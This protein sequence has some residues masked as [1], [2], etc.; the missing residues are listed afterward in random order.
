M[1]SR[2]LALVNPGT[3]DRRPLHQAA[4][5]AKAV[6]GELIVHAVLFDPRLDWDLFSPGKDGHAEAEQSKVEEAARADLERRCEGLAIAPTAIDVSWGHPLDEALKPVLEEHAIDLLVFS[7]RNP[8]GDRLSRAEWHLLRR[9]KANVWLARSGRFPDRPVIAAG[10]DPSDDESTH[11]DRRIVDA[12]TALC[13]GLDVTYDIVHAIG[14]I[15]SAISVAQ[16][17]RQYD[18]ERRERAHRRIDGLFDGDERERVGGVE[19]VPS[20]PAAALEAHCEHRQVNLLI[21]GLY[22]RSRLA[23]LIVGSSIGDVVDRT[24]CDLL[25]VK[26]A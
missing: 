5:A 9:S 10:V 8:S 20:D 18:S 24:D 25:F 12:A 11:L 2:V 7:P 21:I 16:D 26:P 14:G 17:P 1:A 6:G 22:Q 13:A 15:P 23:D 4:L 3:D 19:L